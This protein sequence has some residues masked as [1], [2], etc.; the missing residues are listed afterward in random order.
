MA[1][2]ENEKDPQSEACTLSP[3]LDATAFL[4]GGDGGGPASRVRVH[5]PG[6]ELAVIHTPLTPPLLG[7]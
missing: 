5:G 6:L 2:P 7:W 3:L 1:E 4:G